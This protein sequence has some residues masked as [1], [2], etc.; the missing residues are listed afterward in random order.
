M[1]F[2]TMVPGLPL[3]PPGIGFHC[4]T[5]LSVLNRGGSGDIREGE[6]KGSKKWKEGKRNIYLTCC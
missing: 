2:P 5:E 4:S 3:S 1:T 6:D